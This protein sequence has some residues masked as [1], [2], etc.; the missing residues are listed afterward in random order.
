MALRSLRSLRSLTIAFLCLFFI[1]TALSGIALFT[2]SRDAMRR[3]VDERINSESTTLAP[4]GRQADRATL[5]QHIQE[6]ISHRDTGDLGFVLTDASGRK[7]AG[8]VDLLRKPPLGFSWVGERD[9]IEGLTVGRALTRDLGDGLRLVVIAETEPIDNY[10][11]ARVRLYTTCFGAI[12]IVVL[13]G[14]MLFRRLIGQRI[15]EI[16]RTANAIVE[17]DLQQRVPTLGDDGEFDQQ[18]KSFNR[19]LDRIGEL[20][21]QIR[22]VS[23]DISHELRT[24]LARLR[25][26]LALLEQR[27]SA[28]PVREELSDAIAQADDLLAMFSAMLRISEIE[29][30]SRR[31]AFESLSLGDL[32]TEVTELMEPIAVEAGHELKVGRCDP[33]HS[34]GDRQLLTQMLMNLIENGLRHTPAG[35]WIELAVEERGGDIRLLVRDNGPGISADQRALVMRRFGRLDKSRSTAGH[36]L[37]LPLI[38]AIVRLHHGTMALED[39]APGLQI[40]L[41]FPR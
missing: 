8:N 27:A 22:N 28:E 38:Q 5:V 19:M 37:G 12:I 7:I 10:S 32:V 21:S 2:T 16:Q 23:N 41:T 1:V 11:S 40:I 39:P 14:L 35:S 29:S 30:G 33:A 25:N 3:L 34:V 6:L 31:R 20:M 18:A 17:G 26:Q 4:I 13:G 15:V 36:G 9:R 24:P